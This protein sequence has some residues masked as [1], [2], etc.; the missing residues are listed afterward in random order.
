MNLIGA[1]CNYV[2]DDWV[3][4]LPLSELAFNSAKNEATGTSAFETQGFWLHTD[5]AS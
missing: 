3:R 4:N 2:G 1:T 5:V